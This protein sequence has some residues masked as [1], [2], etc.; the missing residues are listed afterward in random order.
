[1]NV[2]FDPAFKHKPYSADDAS[3]QL[4]GKVAQFECRG[5]ELVDFLPLRV[6][7]C[8]TLV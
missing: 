7:Q 8:F 2:S 4:F 3:S 5:C 6:R 1:M